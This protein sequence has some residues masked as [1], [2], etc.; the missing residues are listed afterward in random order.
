M[1]HDNI[2]DLS[3]FLHSYKTFYHAYIGQKLNKQHA[4]LISVRYAMAGCQWHY[5]SFCRIAEIKKMG[6]TY[7]YPIITN[8]PVI[9]FRE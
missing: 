4:S 7:G 1:S 9:I 2:P 3:A 5:V 8:V 6:Q